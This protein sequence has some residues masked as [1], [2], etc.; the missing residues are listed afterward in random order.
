MRVH[1]GKKCVRKAD[2]VLTGSGTKEGYMIVFDCYGKNN[3][4]LYFM[5]DNII[6]R[7]MKVINW[8]DIVEEFD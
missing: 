1:Q 8:G 4:W 5:V 3:K 7:D 2:T 6:I